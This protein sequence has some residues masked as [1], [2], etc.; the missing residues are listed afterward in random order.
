MSTLPP[1]YPQ[2][3][4]YATPGLGGS[5]YRD[6]EHLN[7]LGIC[8]YIWGGLI[9]LF[10]CF[11]LFYVVMGI[12]F[13]NGKMPGPA[14]PN[15]NGPPPEMGWIFVMIGIGFM[16]FF[17]TLGILSLCAGYCLRARRRQTFCMVV[18]AFNCLSIPLGTI[19]GVFTFVV[20][21]RPT[22]TGLFAPMGNPPG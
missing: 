19:L 5:V 21:A 2:P 12:L 22:M 20:L 17:W 7:I 1:G 4:P 10:G 8:H 9:M 18:A 11:G 14:T 15:V 16:V 6:I 3:I 13:I